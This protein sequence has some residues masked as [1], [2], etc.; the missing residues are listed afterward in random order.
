MKSETEISE[1]VRD[2]LVAELRRRVQESTRK[3]P[4][5]CK[6]NHRHPLD[7]RRTVD[8]EPNSTYN[9]ITD[10]KRTIGLCMYGAEDPTEWPGNIC[11]DEIDAM[12]CPYFDP[13]KTEEEIVDEFQQSIKDPEWLQENLPGIYELR[14][15]LD[16]QVLVEAA[17]GGEATMEADLTVESEPEADLAVIETVEGPSPIVAWFIRVWRAIL[18]K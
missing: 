5:R 16:G 1:R 18:G 13:V 15:V 8:G 4:V 14:W 12:R 2:L 9:Q 3:L 10:S 17:L 6:H 7:A 11:E